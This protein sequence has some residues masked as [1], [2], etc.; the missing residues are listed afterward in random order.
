MLGARG[1]ET[2]QTTKKHALL[3]KERRP[4][5]GEPNLKTQATRRR[6]PYS[7]KARK[8]EGRHG[9]PKQDKRQHPGV[10]KKKRGK[11]TRRKSKS[12]T[13]ERARQAGKHIKKPRGKEVSRKKSNTKRQ[14]RKPYEKRQMP[15]KSREKKKR[16]WI[17]TKKKCKKRQQKQEGMQTLRAATAIHQ[18]RKVRTQLDKTETYV[19]NES[20]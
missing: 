8:K 9:C 19:A 20:D 15:N 3:L 6:N 13:N 2:A 1:H 18:Q 5:I 16:S 12:Y 10:K 7:N 11:Y 14:D 17:E 4:Q